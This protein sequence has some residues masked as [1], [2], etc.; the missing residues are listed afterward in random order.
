MAA[1]AAQAPDEDIGGSPQPFRDRRRV[2]DIGGENEHRHSEK[3]AHTHGV[4][5]GLVDEQTDILSG[6]PE[7]DDTAGEQRQH[8]GNAHGRGDDKGHAKN[9][10][11]GAHA[12]QPTTLEVEGPSAEAT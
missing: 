11:S 8:H 3:G 7:I 1:A 2:H 6:K 5:Q 4:V 10:Q 9:D 12:R